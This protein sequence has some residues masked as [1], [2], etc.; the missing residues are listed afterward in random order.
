MNS[1]TK[2]SIITMI[3][4]VL[5][6]PLNIWLSISLFSL[7]MKVDE[8]IF[9]RYATDNK[10]GED[11]FFSEKIDKETNVGKT[12]QEIFQLKGE[13]QTSSIQDTFS[14]LLE[15]EHFFIQEIEKNDVYISY[16]KSKDLTI[17]DLIT[18]M[19]L[20]ANLNS[21]IMNGSFYLSALILILLMYLLFRFRLELYFIAGVLYTFIT[22][23]TFTSGI[24]ANIFFKP[25]RWLSQ[26]MHIDQDYKFEEYAMYIEFLP[27]VKEAFL[28][29]IIFDT[30]VLAW[31]EGWKRRRSMKLT[32]IYY[33][34]DEVINVLS[35]L[36][37]SD[38]NSPFIRV[39]KIKV[40]FKYLHK[41]AKTK[42]K[43]PALRE[44]KRL[45][46]M[47]IHQEQLRALLASDVRNSLIILKQELNKSVVL[48]SGIDQH[49]KLV[50]GKCK[51]NLRDL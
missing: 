13:T 28:T 8:G 3:M 5:Y 14:K 39:S 17:Q 25:M 27:T 4:L 9:Y 33:S 2:K 22:L 44:V 40:D 41:F 36:E 50:M 32:E 31:R 1:I 42:K 38:S 20:I 24:F 26:A 48:K 35:Y 45:T 29:F 19:N 18:Y 49:Y 7:V 43:D 21:K 30:L 34:I 12:I 11:I 16:L 6:I 51:H 37:I 15:N 47:F 23:S 10:Y 46:L